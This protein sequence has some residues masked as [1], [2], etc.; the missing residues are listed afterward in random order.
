MRIAANLAAR[1]TGK[2]AAKKVA[3]KPVKKAPVKKPVTGRKA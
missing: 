2:P 1:K 3:A